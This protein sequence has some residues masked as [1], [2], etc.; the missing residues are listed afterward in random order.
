MKT[1]LLLLFSLIFTTP[2]YSQ[3]LQ[4]GWELWF[5]YQYRN[6]AQEL[7]G[8]DIDVFKAIINQA[9]YQ[10]NYVELP[11][12]RHLRYIKSGKVDIAFG[13]SYTKE[14]A[15][16]AYFTQAYRQETV[17]LFTR[18][19]ATVNL[20]KLSDIIHSQYI[21]GIEKGYYYGDKFEQL[22]QEPSFKKHIKAVLDIEENIDL[23]L[24]GKIDGLLA[25]PNTVSAFVKKYRIENELTEHALPI[26]Q[27]S[28]H[29][30]LSKKT[31]SLEALQRFNQAI[32]TLKINGTLAAISNKW[33]NPETK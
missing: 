7:V 2:V 3:Y 32:T 28:I 22:M 18:K 15:S 23:L 6:K 1:A 4:V 20:D 30:M 29:I 25:D 10:A 14:R 19:K 24:K 26:Y 21:I 9:G 12:Q 16:Y 17:R 27:T 5:P 33:Q 31:L 11:W 8:L 13:A